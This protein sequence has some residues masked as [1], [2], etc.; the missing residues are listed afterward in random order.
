MAA[1]RAVVRYLP[2]VALAL[3]TLGEPAHAQLITGNDSLLGKLNL[4]HSSDEPRQLD[5]PELCHRLDHLSEE[6]RDDGLV[7]FKQ[8]D[9]FS[10]A[11][12]THF[13]NDFDQQMRQDLNLFHLVLAARINRL[14]GATTTQTTNLAAALSAPGTAAVNVANSSGSTMPSAPSGPPNIPSTATGTPLPMAGSFSNFGLDTNVPNPSGPLALGVDPT[15]YL[16]E[17]KRFLDHLSQI[18]RINFGPDQNDSSGYGLYLVRLP[19]SITPGEQ[20]HQGYGAEVA[21]TVEHE[22]APDSLPRTFQSLVINDIVDQLGPV[23]YEVIR[24]GLVDKYEIPRVVEEKRREVV[25]ER[26]RAA[27][28]PATVKELT[29]VPVGMDQ[30]QRETYRSQYQHL[31]Q[32]AGQLAQFIGRKAP[33]GSPQLVSNPGAIRAINKRLDLLLEIYE[34]GGR[35][36]VPQ[37]E[38]LI[39]RAK[40]SLKSGG[41]IPEAD[42]F[43]IEDA[44]VCIVVDSAY[45]PPGTGKP[46]QL[47]RRAFNDLNFRQYIDFVLELYR[48]ALTDD[49]NL[50]DDALGLTDEQKKITETLLPLS[51][52]VLKE[53]N[54]S[55]PS[56]RSSK[57]IYPIAPREVVNFFLPDNILLLAKDV[58][59]SLMTTNPRATDVRNYLRHSL[60]PA[61]DAMAM[62]TTRKVTDPQLAPLNDCGLMQRISDAIRERK[63]VQGAGQDSLPM[64][65]E[66]LLDRL[67]QTRDNIRNKDGSP[68]PIAAFSWAIALD[69]ALLDY[70]WLWWIPKVL[71]EHGIER[72]LPEGQHFYLGNDYLVQETKD[73][74]QEFVKTHWPIITFALDP[75]TDQQNVADS[76]NLKRDLQLAVSFAFATGQISFSQLNT[77][78]RQ[79]EQSSD[80]IALNR[81]VTGFAHG[82]E[83]FGFRFTPRVQNP[84]MQRTN[85]G[86]IASQLISGGPGPDYQIKKSK[87]EAGMRELTAVL[88]IPTFLPS[89]RMHFST[90]W[91]RLD[92]PEH[93]VFHSARAMERGR[94]VQGLTEAAQHA[95][96]LQQYRPAD[97]RVLQ[98]KLRQLEAMLPMQSRVVQ[99]P[100]ENTA[101]GFDL[102]SDGATALVPELSGYDGVDIVKEGQAADIFIY[103]K[104]INLLDTRVIIGGAFVPNQN[105]SVT[106]TS[107]STTQST[108]AGTATTGTTLGTTTQ[109]LAAQPGSVDILSREV[110]HVQIPAT[111]SPTVTTGDGKSYFEVYLATPN[112][113][114]NRVLVPCQP[115]G[116]SPT[117]NA[118]DLAAGTDNLEL[119]IFYQWVTG[120][121]GRPKLILTDDPTSGGKKSLQITW[122]DRAGFAPKTL[123]ANF[124]ATLVAGQHL[125]FSLPADSGTS[126]DYS[127]DRYKIATTLLS[128]FQ[129]T[130]APLSALPPTILL[131]I[132]VQPYVPNDSMGFRVRKKEKPLNTR[133]SVKF[134]NNVTNKEVSPPGSDTSAFIPIPRRMLNETISGNLAKSDDSLVQTTQGPSQF[135]LSNSLPS[136][137]LP[138]LPN[139]STLAKTAPALDA[140]TLSQQVGSLTLP[141]PN[142]GATPAVVNQAI[143]QVAQNLA[144]P[145][146]IVVNPSPV[147]VIAPSATPASTSKHRSR[148]AQLFHRGPNPPQTASRSAR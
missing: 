75:V 77:F 106:Q 7:V 46:G 8:P 137:A 12:M 134:I 138:A 56:T 118:Y 4:F 83:T 16:D 115:K 51:A 48:T 42:I 10:Q 68:R 35:H 29:P 125:M 99:L 6:L 111:A 32:Q 33:P 28:F 86:V 13:R 38:D 80:V 41:S 1:L 148:L 21:V 85:L 25:L 69:A 100:Y 37:F 109:T 72:T 31:Y 18:R 141:P 74:F 94:R 140:S 63:F 54:L 30:K 76:F 84:P 98:A 26:I 145:P 112:G 91:F 143:N 128:Q 105:P 82:N 88:L 95:C 60:W 2:C 121:D 92:D 122:D 17:K 19:V 113:I 55:L 131:A 47:A 44:L 87:L 43:P 15:V 40:T 14:D 3:I 104:Y 103:G 52:E 71:E 36:R 79:I 123:Q 110:I 147:V 107:Q 130:V 97:V 146:Q 27:L 135:P 144:H 101:S 127:V 39:P 57:Q 5:V 142:L 133:L 58:K 90:N 120:A 126:D 78:R 24:S 89:M 23:V 59:Q 139:V 62:N 53:L 136:L 132:S 9:V 119:N 93:L 22:F 70:S 129:Q 81:T 73:Y 67:Q 66:E 96:S 114:S 102:Y 45:Y 50:I 64:L 116:T 49:I 11:R 20:T 61:Y 34:R 117:L 124:T 65:F 108:T